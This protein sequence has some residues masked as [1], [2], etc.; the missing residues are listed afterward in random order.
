MKQGKSKAKGKNYTM[1]N[2]KILPSINIDIHKMRLQVVSV[3]V[4]LTSAQVYH[5]TVFC[6]LL[7][8]ISVIVVK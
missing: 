1:E 3:L 7:Y 4:E 5:E 6:E 8:Y 2:G